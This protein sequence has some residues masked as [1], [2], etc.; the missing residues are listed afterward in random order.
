MKFILTK[1]GGRRDSTSIVDF[2]FLCGIH[3]ELTVVKKI[4]QVSNYP[5]LKVRPSTPHLV[6][7]A[8]ATTFAGKFT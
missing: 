2:Y 8:C 7:Y 4:A 6:N 1:K 5:F 3:P